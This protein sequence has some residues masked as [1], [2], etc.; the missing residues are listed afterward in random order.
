MSEE[1]LL[2]P[3]ASGIDSPTGFFLEHIHT[4]SD[5]FWGPALSLITFAVVFISLSDD[6]RTGFAAGSFAAMVVTVLLI[7]FGLMGSNALLLV[8]LMVVIGIA[9]NRGGGRI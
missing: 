7:P 4:V 6:A 3:R 5:G 2:F 1:D 9:I 8:S